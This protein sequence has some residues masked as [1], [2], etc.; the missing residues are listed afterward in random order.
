MLELNKNE[1][2]IK[3]YGTYYLIKVK[4]P[5]NKSYNTTVS[6]WKQTSSERVIRYEMD[7][8]LNNKKYHI[9]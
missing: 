1:E 2:F 5:E 9:S 7:K 3:E 4:C 8:R 6:K